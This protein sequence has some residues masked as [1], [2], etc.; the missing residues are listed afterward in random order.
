VPVPG[1]LVFTAGSYRFSMN[2]ASVVEIVAWIIALII[3]AAWGGRVVQWLDRA[4][5]GRNLKTRFTNAL[6]K[7]RDVSSTPGE[8]PP[9]DVAHACALFTDV[10]TYLDQRS[11]AYA[12]QSLTNV[13]S[14]LAKAAQR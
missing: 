3:L 14:I 5:P 9:A 10:Q 8:L 1:V 12:R 13:E 11:L 6:R 7:L 4:G 2:L